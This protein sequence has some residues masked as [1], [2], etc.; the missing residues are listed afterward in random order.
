MNSV[1]RLL[2]NALES[3]E[4]M[5]KPKVTSL[6]GHVQSV[7]VQN[8]V[9]LYSAIIMKAEVDGDEAKVREVGQILLDKLPMFAQSSDLEVQERVCNSLL[10]LLV[11]NLVLTIEF[12]CVATSLLY[13]M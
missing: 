8:I 11:N 12:C 4:A 3:L 1:T 6:P 10:F 5:F 2:P 13:N 7:F 9:K